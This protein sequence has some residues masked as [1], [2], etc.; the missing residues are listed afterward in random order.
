M[1]KWQF[2]KLIE[3]HREP[4]VSSL[5]KPVCID[6]RI[7]DFLLGNPFLDSTTAEILHIVQNKKNIDA[8]HLENDIKQQIRNIS[9]NL[10]E[11]REVECNTVVFLYGPDSVGKRNASIAIS[12]TLNIPLLEVSV[13]HLLKNEDTLKETVRRIIRETLILKCSLLIKDMEALLCEGE[14]YCYLKDFLLKEVG[15]CLLLTFL[16]CEDNTKFSFKNEL[17]KVRYIN[18]HFPI[19]KFP[20][21]KMIWE[22]ALNGQ[23]ESQTKLTPSLLADKFRFT[24]RQIKGAIKSAK[25]RLYL[26]SGEKEFVTDEDI[27][28]GCREQNNQKLLEL[29]VKITPK[30]LWNDIILPKDPLMQL[31]EICDH[32]KYHNLVYR[33]WGFEKKISLGSGLNVLFSGSSGTGKTMAAEILANELNLELYKIDLSQVVSKYIGETE[34]N[35]SRIFIEAETSNAILFFDEADALFGKR[36]EVKDAHDRYANIEIGYLLQKMEEYEGMTILATNLRQNMDEAFTR[37]LKFIV[38]FPFPDENYRCKIWKIHFTKELP[39]SDDIDFEFLARQ[40][41]LAG[42]NIKNVV[43]NSSFLAAATDGKKVAMKHL[44][45]ATKRELQKMGKLCVMGDFGKYYELI[46]IGDN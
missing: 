28:I 46:S 14:K 36:S 29:A 45:H 26:N 2:L 44:I 13:K 17:D 23:M 43:I 37:R 6:E 21:R 30:F 20:I 9:K 10:N 33:D 3:D 22:K 15:N 34:K 25:N 8:L 32:L 38:D 19:P 42:G 1:I 40:F 31:K 35:L 39:C 41:K 18:I 27:F 5:S 4:A 7:V 24:E 11:T 12:S 16:S